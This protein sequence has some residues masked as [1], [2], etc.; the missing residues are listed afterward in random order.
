M[1]SVA[2]LATPRWP[3]SQHHL[4]PAPP[5]VTHSGVFFGGGGVV[6]VEEEGKCS[7]AWML[8]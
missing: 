5:S 4:I 7:L 6:R 1:A 3:E 2:A 8:S